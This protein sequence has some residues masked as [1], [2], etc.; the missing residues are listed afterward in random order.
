LVL[1]EVYFNPTSLR[2]VLK[3]VEYELEKGK[4]NGVYNL[5]NA[6]ITNHY[7]Y[8]QFID[9]ALGSNKN[10]SKVIKHSRSFTNY[11]YFLMDCS[12]INR[13]IKLTHWTK[14]LVD[15]LGDVNT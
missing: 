1:D 2:Q 9:I 8:G 3:V 4:L 5:A 11:G 14:D 7:K 10:I 6:G 12:K 15:Y 13:Y